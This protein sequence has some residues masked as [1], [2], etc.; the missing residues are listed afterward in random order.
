MTEPPSRP[1]SWR[2]WIV[3]PHSG[4]EVS[5]PDGQV[6][7]IQIDPK[8]FLVTEPFRFS[9]SAVEQSLIE[10]LQ[11]DGRST[12]EARRAVDDARTF[13]P[14][15]ENPTDMASVPLF[16]RWFENP[17]GVHTLAAIIH[18]DLITGQPNAGALGSDTLADRFF[19]QMMKAAEVPWLK[20]W[21]MWAAVAIRSRWAAGGVR[22]VS[23]TVWTALAVTGMTAAVLA[24]GGALFDWSTPL[25]PWLLVVIA[26][27]LPFV[28][29]PLWGRQYG[30]SLVAALA[31][32]WILPPALLGL[33]G[34]LVYRLLEL[35]VGKL[36]LR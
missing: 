34:Y 14:S 27:V 12:D 19:R 36:G 32:L 33:V 3:S 2:P 20:R 16:M 28:S 9:D 29:A 13:T 1:V 35:V 24:I 8:Q 31:A 22:R 11:R 7:L 4:F 10:R 25:D 26:V 30:A 5:D 18:D 17:Y 6:G 21:I 23:M 15:T